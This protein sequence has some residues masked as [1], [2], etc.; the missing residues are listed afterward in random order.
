MIHFYR[1]VNRN[2][3]THQQLFERKRTN[4]QEKMLDSD[5]KTFGEEPGIWR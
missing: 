2:R 5:T 3:T 1:E 4:C